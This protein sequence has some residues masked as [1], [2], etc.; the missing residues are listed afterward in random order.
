M[1]KAVNI[2]YRRL[3]RNGIP[4]PGSLKNEI[5]R[6]MRTQRA[7]RVIGNTVALRKFDLDQ[8]GRL[9]LLNRIT[10]DAHWD[11]PFF[12]GAACLL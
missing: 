10:D 2:Q 5:V 4:W 6:A 3:D 1:A 8:D 11:Q 12:G 9:T 7:G